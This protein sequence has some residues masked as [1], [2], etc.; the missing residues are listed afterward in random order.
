MAYLSGM[1]VRLRARVLA[2]MGEICRARGDRRKALRLL[3]QAAEIQTVHGY[4]GYLSDYT[5]ASLAKATSVQHRALVWLNSAKEIQTASGNRMGLS[6]SLLLEARISRDEI[7]ANNLYT[8]LRSC[9]N[10]IPALRRSAF[11]ANVLTRW[12]Q[13]TSGANLNDNS[14]TFGGL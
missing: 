10:D 12:N 6:V 9:Q 7:N 4:L 8:Q 11:L 14:D 5:Y 3:H 2:T 13:W 1:E